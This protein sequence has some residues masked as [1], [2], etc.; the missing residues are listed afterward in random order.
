MNTIKHMETP[1]TGSQRPQRTRL[2]TNN[3]WLIC[4][5][6]LLLSTSLYM[7]IPTLP[8]WLVVR[9][10]AN[11]FEIGGILALSGLVAFMLGPFFNYL[12]DR[13]PRKS[14][15]A[16][17][18]LGVAACSLGFYWVPVL[19][20]AVALR[21]VQGMLQGVALM[22]S[23]STLAIDLTTSPHRTDVNNAFAWFGRLGLSVGPLMGL[24]VQYLFGFHNVFIASF[25]IGMLA[26]L[27]VLCLKV[28]FRAPLCPPKF[29][30]DR[31]WLPNGWLMFLQTIPVAA[32]TGILLGTIHRYEFYVFIMVG[33]CLALLALHFVFLNADIRSEIVSGNILW[34][35]GLL[36]L[37]FREGTPAF[38]ASSIL[39]G[40]GIGLT[41]ARLLVFFIKLSHHCERGSAN[42][43][44]MFAWELGIG[45]GLFLGYTVFPDPLESYWVC[46]W[47]LAG[48]LV[49]YLLLTHRWF[50]AHKVR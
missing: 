47:I 5:S 20:W 19:G 23:G 24:L 41:V 45:L 30:L 22:A 12:V 48:A 28:P 33:F 6:H 40:M 1:V 34:A 3:I 49:F 16:W 46:L 15:C 9:Y 32:V 18:L 35:A 44:Y 36:L 38:Y 10:G 21:V 50:M 42:T 7:L 31:F 4:L 43:S 29:S 13:F 11:S 8:V 26:C 27:C 39:I 14:V 2:W 17:G 37:I 25:V